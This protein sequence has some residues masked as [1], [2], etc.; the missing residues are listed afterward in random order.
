MQAAYISR[1]DL[2]VNEKDHA[3]T[4][5]ILESLQDKFALSLKDLSEIPEY[6]D[7]VKSPE[8]KIWQAREAKKKSS[9]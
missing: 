4:L 2:A 6:D 1:L 8:Y 9:P 3:T 5:K 7:F